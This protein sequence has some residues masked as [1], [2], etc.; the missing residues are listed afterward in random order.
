MSNPYYGG[1]PPPYGPP[2]SG[3]PYGGPPG[4]P[5]V[6][7][8]K[9]D[10]PWI[11]AVVAAVV[12][13]LVTVLVIVVNRSG[14]GE[15]PHSAHATATKTTAS[16]PTSAPAPPATT[17]APAQGITYEIAGSVTANL[18]V[19][20]VDTRGKYNVEVVDSLPWTRT[21][22]PEPPNAG[23]FVLSLDPDRQGEKLDIVITLKRG[24]RVLKQCHGT[25]PCT[26]GS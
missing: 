13:S 4:Y 12:I 18:W 7:P 26:V 19:N 1:P 5:P 6:P 22:I 21:V 25:D 3:P 16:R 8:Q 17:V 23:I 24:G 10:L 2:P 20:Y 15:H 11:I 9:S 14:G